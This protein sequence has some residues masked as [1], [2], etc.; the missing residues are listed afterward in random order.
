VE[1]FFR[2]LEAGLGLERVQV[3]GLT[4]LRKL[5][6]VIVGLALFLWEVKREE[7]PFKALLIWLGGKLGLKS[8]RDG[9]Y[10]LMRGLSGSSTTRPPMRPSN[11]PRPT[12]YPTPLRKI[13]MG[14]ALPDAWAPSL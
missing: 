8:E 11:V 3:R 13:L 7:G 9:P 4:S 10:L 5:V 1:E 12:S 14:K 6:A 2:L